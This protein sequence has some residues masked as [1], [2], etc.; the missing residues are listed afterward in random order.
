LNLLDDKRKDNAHFT[1][2]YLGSGLP[3]TLEHLVYVRGSTK[4]DRFQ[5]RHLNK[6]RS[7]L[8]RQF[9]PL[10]RFQQQLKKENEILGQDFEHAIDDHLLGEDINS[11]NDGSSLDEVDEEI[12]NRSETK[13]EDESQKNAKS[14]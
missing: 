11:S 7:W 3:N 4:V 8:I 12:F 6:K 10:K 14:K 2:G 5:L 9:N 1:G 13:G